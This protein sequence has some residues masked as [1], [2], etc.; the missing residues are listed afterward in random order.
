M[1]A[2]LD[3][4]AWHELTHAYGSAEDV[5]EMLRAAAAPDEETADA[6]V[7]DLYGSVL[8]Q[9]SVYSSTPVVLPFVLDIAA[10]PRSQCR[11][12]LVGF[13]GT[14]VA[15]GDARIRD[16]VANRADRLVELLADEDDKV[17]EMAAYTLGHLDSVP[18]DRLRWEVEQE[19]IVRASILVAASRLDLQGAR[20]WL[21]SALTEPGAVQAAAAYVIGVNSLPWTSAVTE[22]LLNS[23]ADGDPLPYWEWNQNWLADLV[24]A[25]DDPA[26]VREIV[27]ALS[28]SDDEEVR[29][30]AVYAA[31]D[32]MR[33]RRSC[34]GPGPGPGA[35]AAVG[36]SGHEPAS[37]RGVRNR[38]QRR[39]P[40]RRG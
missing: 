7:S 9:G 33:A 28:R 31:G 11:Y 21:T 38:V 20:A 26:V 2:G 24:S 22:A 10:D 39:C 16:V 8:H 37:R 25:L 19:P 4:V 3:D 17:R 13:V 35:R 32:A 34:P 12:L 6:G 15:S 30:T 27:A 29:Q 23:W 14:A 1:L 36:G 18:L 5:P 40:A